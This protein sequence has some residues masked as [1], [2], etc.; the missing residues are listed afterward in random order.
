[1]AKLRSLSTLNAISKLCHQVASTVIAIACMKK[2]CATVE[3]VAVPKVVGD[4]E[5]LNVPMRLR[6]A[7]TK[8]ADSE[9]CD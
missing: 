1:M 4:D 9:V 3:I 6:S 7:M 8:I 2:D 5:E